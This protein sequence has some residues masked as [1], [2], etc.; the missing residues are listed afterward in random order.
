MP[1]IKYKEKLIFKFL[2]KIED[3]NVNMNKINSEL[4]KFTKA[5]SMD[6]LFEKLI[7]M[8]KLDAAREQSARGDVVSEAELDSE[9]KKGSNYLSKSVR[10]SN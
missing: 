7:L 5:F 8:E 1:Q 9:I 2:K 4:N 10:F 3:C 6:E